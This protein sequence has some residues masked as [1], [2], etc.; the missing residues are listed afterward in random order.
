[1]PDQTLTFDKAVFQDPH[2]F[3]ALV[4][5]EGP[6]HQVE[7]PLG[8]KG[9]VI[10]RYPE[11]RA[12]LN[13]ARLSKDAEGFMRLMRAQQPDLPPPADGNQ[14]F[15]HM[16]NADP[17]DHTRLRK[18][19]TKVFTARRIEELRPR[20]Q[21]ISDALLATMLAKAGDG[22]MDLLDEYAFP[23]P[24]TVICELLGVP[25][26][27]HDDFR[28]WSNAAISSGPRDEAQA[29]ERAMGEYLGRLVEAKRAEPADDLV[30]AL[31][32]A[33]DDEDQLSSGEVLA[34]I[35][36]LMVAGH[37]TTVNLIGNGLL[38][39]LR[40]PGQLAALRADRTLLPSAIEE[41]LRFDGPLN[42]ATFRFTA[43]PIELGGVTIPKDE[44]VVISLL[45]ANRDP[46]QYSDPDRFDVTRAPSHVA[47]GHGIHFCLGAPLARMEADIAFTGLL[48]QFTDIEL[49]VPVEELRYRPSSLMHGL[50]Q[51]PVLLRTRS[52]VIGR[53]DTT[54]G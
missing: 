4:R 32:R 40:N 12:A 14:M 3:Y 34:M 13:D 39:L 24:I 41:F 38:A 20:V 29:A 18:L 19:V 48:D 6:V 21:E 7:L 36:L 52:A 31:I 16:L 11:A 46:R 23:L 51:L 47:F 26:E 43:E 8:T 27:A 50:A 5:D 9:W 42:L 25:H 17:P 10:T 37:E 53:S 15:R 22:P 35:F 33:S 49:A 2:A 30:S 44:F 54:T 1:M 45:A 28:K